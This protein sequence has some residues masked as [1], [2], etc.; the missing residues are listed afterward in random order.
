MYNPDCATCR[1]GRTHNLDPWYLNLL[2]DIFGSP[3]SRSVVAER[4][5]REFAR[6]QNA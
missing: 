4:T 3:T 2:H 6:A 5:A 1:I